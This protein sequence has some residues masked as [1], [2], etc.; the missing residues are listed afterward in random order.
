[1]LVDELKEREKKY[2]CIAGGALDR[3]MLLKKGKRHT[4]CSNA[5][6]PRSWAR[7]LPCAKEAT[8][9]KERDYDG[10]SICSFLRREE[11]S[12]LEKT[13]AGRLSK[14]DVAG[15]IGFFLVLFWWF[16]KIDS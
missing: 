16:L 11:R 13:V 9:D 1:V 8:A 14:G 4:E 5:Q 15:W 2:L 7:R 10:A 12:R 6:V 3:G